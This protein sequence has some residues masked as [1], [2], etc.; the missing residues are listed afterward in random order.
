MQLYSYWYK[1]LK[2]FE[3]EMKTCS[4]I[5]VYKRVQLHCCVECISFCCHFTQNSSVQNVNLKTIIELI[6]GQ[7]VWVND[8]YYKYYT[9]DTSLLFR[10]NNSSISMWSRTSTL[11]TSLTKL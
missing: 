6:N 11:C 3:S 1:N 7:Y 9:V 2:R 8:V 4:V 5:Y 10:G